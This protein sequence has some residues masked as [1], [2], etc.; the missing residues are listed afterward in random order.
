MFWWLHNCKRF[1]NFQDKFDIGNVYIYQIQ[2]P[3]ASRRG[4][5]ALFPRNVI[6]PDTVSLPAFTELVVNI[7]KDLPQNNDLVSGS[8]FGSAIANL[9]DLQKDGFEDFAV[10]AP[11]GGTDHAGAVFI[12]RG[13]LDNSLV[14]GMFFF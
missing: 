12:Y 5:R 14:T 10:G 8:R 4:R 13:S 3:Q 7:L 1:I 2:K 9:G 11:Y 6:F